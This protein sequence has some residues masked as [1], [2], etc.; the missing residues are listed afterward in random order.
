M[1]LSIFA[2][3]VFVGLLLIVIGYFTEDGAVQLV[4]YSFLFICGTALLSNAVT[5]HSG[6]EETSRYTYD[7][8]KLLSESST[9][10]VNTYSSAVDSYA[11]TLGIWLCIMSVLGSAFAIA[12][13]KN[14]IKSSRSDDD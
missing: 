14:G 10:S 4:G 9:T 13:L 8:D 1:I 12:N 11:R 6:T 2:L 5:Y 7:G 3:F